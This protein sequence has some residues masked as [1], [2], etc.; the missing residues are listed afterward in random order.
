MKERT[1]REEEELRMVEN[2]RKL[3]NATCAVSNTAKRSMC[4]E[5]DEMLTV[6]NVKQI[7]SMKTNSALSSTFSVAVQPP[8]YAGFYSLEIH[9]IAKPFKSKQV[10]SWKII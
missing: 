4:D 3:E 8:Q 9:F 7:D 2:M 1:G 6:F 5:F 10:Y